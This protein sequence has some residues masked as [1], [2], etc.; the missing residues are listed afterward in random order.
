MQA[1]IQGTEEWLEMRRNAI[2]ASDAPIIMGVSPWKTPHALWEEK[3]GLRE[4]QP[5]TEAMKRGSLLE[6]PARGEFEK[7]TGLKMT[8]RV[9]EHP[10][11]DW[12]IASLDGISEDGKSIVEIKCPGREDHLTA[13]TGEVP[14]KY[15]AQLQH[16]LAVT[17][18]YMVYYYSYDGERGITIEVKRDDKYIDQ[19]ISMELA[20]W[21]CVQNLEPPKLTE[22]DYVT[23]DDDLW[24][25]TTA[26]WLEVQAQ[27]EKLVERQEALRQALIDLSGGRNTMGAGIRVQRVVRS[28]SINYRMIPELRNV[29]L[30]QYRKKPVESWRISPEG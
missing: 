18:L 10:T 1:F 8:P 12:M 4:T 9:M 17:G 15:Y 14:E 28:G 22:R 27:L 7:A 2:G 21:N 24:Q 11:Y 3:L 16:Q 19:L 6:E 5:T 20:F 29:N 26:S 13:L 23:R 30:E 25:T